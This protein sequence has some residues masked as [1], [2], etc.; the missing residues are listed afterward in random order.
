MTDRAAGLES[1]LAGEHAA[2]YGY[3]V[4][5]AVLVKLQAPVPLIAAARGGL[6]A[7]RVS[8]DRLSDAIAAF[9]GTPPGPLAAYQIPFALDTPAAVLR[10]LIALEDRLCGI[11]ANAV[12]VSVGRPLSADVLGAAAVRAAQLRLL[13]GLPAAGAVLAFPGLPRLR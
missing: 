4:A 8:R 5:G 9:A 7:H 12:E 2:V 6:D 13:S 1:V 10:L 11:A 3:G